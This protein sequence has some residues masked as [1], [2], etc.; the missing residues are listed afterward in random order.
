MINIKVIYKNLGANS[1][2]VIINIILQVVAVPVFIKYWGVNLY[3]EWLV[4]T[5]FTAY[6]SMT[7]IGLNTVTA[8]DFSINY[9]QGKHNKCNILLNNNF[10]F[11]V[12]VFSTIIS[13]LTV[14]IIISLPFKFKFVFF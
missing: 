10:F 3:G 6:F 5:A 1:L 14:V 2:S 4:L 8:N 13:G 9:V 11:I 12:T 7:D